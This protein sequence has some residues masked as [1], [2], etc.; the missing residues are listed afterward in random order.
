MLSRNFIIGFIFFIL[1]VMEVQAQSGNLY[2][3]K[4]DQGNE[5]IA[6]QI[7]AE[8]VKNGYEIMNDRGQ[9]IREVSR[10]LSDEERENQADSLES[11]RLAEEARIQQEEDDTLSLRLYRSPEEVIRRRDATLEELDAQL[12]VLNAL[13]GYAEDDVDR[14]QVIIDNNVE[15]E[16][17]VPQNILSQFESASEERDRLGRQIARIENERADSISTAQRNI[18]RLMELLNTEE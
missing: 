14:I 6:T 4:D 16:K 7:P 8:F 2:R 18:D 13:R 5:I 15:A 12:T 9:V 3:Y 10:T 11:V 17:E 1:T